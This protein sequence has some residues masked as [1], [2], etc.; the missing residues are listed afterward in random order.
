[1]RS[2]TQIVQEEVETPNPSIHGLGNVGAHVAATLRLGWRPR[3]LVTVV[4]ASVEDIHDEV[5]D[6]GKVLRV[7]LVF[8]KL[9]KV[10]RVIVDEQVGFDLVS[11]PITALSSLAFSAL[12]SF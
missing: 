9:F 11:I 10:A 2:G 3:V 8:D 6:A 5:S 7:L 1:M 12:F 4:I